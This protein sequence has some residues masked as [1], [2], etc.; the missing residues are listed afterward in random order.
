[1][2]RS[3]VSVRCLWQVAVH[4]NGIDAFKHLAGLL[5]WGVIAPGRA[6]LADCT[7]HQLLTGES[8]NI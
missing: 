7:L 4:A 3:E 6:V 5:Y 1:M 2:S 8:I